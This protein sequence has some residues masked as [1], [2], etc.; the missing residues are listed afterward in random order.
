MKFG[1]RIA[2]VVLGFLQFGVAVPE[3]A[4]GRKDK[5][6]VKA[7]TPEDELEACRG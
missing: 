1:A 5:S 3:G 4:E 6:S 7:Y 2:K